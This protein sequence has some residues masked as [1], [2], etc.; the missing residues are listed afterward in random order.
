MNKT[1]SW[2]QLSFNS[3]FQHRLRSFLSMLGII[4]GVMAVLTMISISEGAKKELLEQI[5][6]LGT[7][8][9]FIKAAQLTP[10]QKAAAVEKLSSGLTMADGSR[11][12]AG[13][14]Q[15]K[16]IAGLNEISAAVR[17]I[18]GNESP[19]V[20]AV[21]PSYAGLMKILVARGRFFT[22]FDQMNHDMVCVIGN[23]L[24]T[25]L[26]KNGNIGNLIRIEDHL[27]KII[28]H[29]Q[30][31]DPLSPGKKK[32]AISV[33]NYNEMLMIP[34]GADGSIIARDQETQ[35]SYHGGITELIV[36]VQDS[37]QVMAA[38]KVIHRI[39]EI[40]HNHVP[41]YQI[42]IPRALFIQA[43]QTQKLFNMVLGAIAGISLLV[44]GIGI[45]NIMLAT[46][47]ERTREIGIRRAV[48]ASRTDI[49]QQFLIESIILTFSGG[50]IGVVLGSACA[51]VVSRIGQWQTLITPWAVL[52]SVIMAVGVGIFFG[53]YPAVRASRMDPIIALRY[54]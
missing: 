52:L 53:L 29:L 26:G 12:L 15:A 40:A 17:G 20:V 23:T 11:I 32:T 34:L 35:L 27:F 43:R 48:G 25:R 28:G 33:R 18:S 5:E 42:V 49:V 41:D 7:K 31:V 6:R 4:F 8:N 2:I 10:S 9:I 44:G 47:Y 1:L 19:Q 24:A 39:M 16:L 51:V 54:E 38:G 37:D 50:L 45:M 36:Q 14:S 13:C 22:P 46:V 21:S 30:E 3:I